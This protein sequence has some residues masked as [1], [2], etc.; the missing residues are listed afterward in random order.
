MANIESWILIHGSRV[1]TTAFWS[2]ASFSCRDGQ[3]MGSCTS[4]HH[5]FLKLKAPMEKYKPSW[6]GLVFSRLGP[7]KFCVHILCSESVYMEETKQIRARPPDWRPSCHNQVRNLPWIESIYTLVSLASRWHAAPWI[8]DGFFLC[9]SSSLLLFSPSLVLVQ[10]MA[11]AR[12]TA[13]LAAAREQAS[14][15][16]RCSAL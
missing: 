6:I 10:A 9:S 1:S 15:I 7:P 14:E 13:L 2:L 5:F 3:R 8:T 4:P 12:R 11:M 16:G